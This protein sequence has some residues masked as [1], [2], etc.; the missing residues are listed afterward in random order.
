MAE[1]HPGAEAFLPD[2]HSMKAVREASAGC[3]V[4]GLYREATQTVFG[5][6]RRSADLM[7]VGETPGDREDLEGRPFV[8]PAGRELDQAFAAVGLD[9]R[10]VY[11]TNAVKHFKVEG[12]GK[13]RIHKTP[14]PAP[15]AARLPG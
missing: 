7:L 15:G 6:G 11:V 5:Q 9:R 10:D 2:R 13:R 3:R 8:G 14:S 4:C 12:R 1:F